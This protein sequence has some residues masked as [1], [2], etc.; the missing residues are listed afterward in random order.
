M[1]RFVPIP[2]ASE[3]GHRLES[4]KQRDLCSLTL[5]TEN[6]HGAVEKPHEMKFRCPSEGPKD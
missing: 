1:A 2:N 6:I 4:V 3:R 5:F